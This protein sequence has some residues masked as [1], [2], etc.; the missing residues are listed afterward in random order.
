MHPRRQL[1]RQS[2]PPSDGQ[3]PRHRR[4]PSPQFTT[5]D[6]FYRHRHSFSGLDPRQ[7][8]MHPR[9]Q[10]A[11]QSSTSS[12]DRQPHRRRTPS[13]QFAADGRFY[14]HRHSFS[15]LDPWETKM[16]LCRQLAQQSSPP[17]DGRQPDNRFYR[18]ERTSPPTSVS[19]PPAIPHS[20]EDGF[21]HPPTAALHR[22]Q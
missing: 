7:A 21:Q 14:R 15:G 11:R 22:R 10:L 18:H 6:R 12:D 20:P 5:H 13:R 17:S 16:H 4:T 2:S 9:R 8:E 3:Q 1:A 19:P